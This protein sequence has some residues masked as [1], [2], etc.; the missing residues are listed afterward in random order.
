MRSVLKYCFTIIIVLHAFLFS[1]GQVMVNFS[2]G[3]Y[4]QTIEGLAFAQVVNSLTVDIRG[5]ITIRVRERNQRELVTIKVPSMNFRPGVNMIDRVAFANSKI[6]FGQSDRAYMLSNTGRF[7]EGELEYCYEVNLSESK[8]PNLPDVFEN[9]FTS[10]NQPLTPLLLINPIDEDEM[11]NTRPN[12]S[13]QPPMPLARDARFRIIV[14]EL[15]DKQGPE[16]AISLNIP[17]I[18]QANMATGNLLY[19]AQAPDLKVG[20]KYVWQVTVYSGATIITKSEIWIFTVKCSEEKK[21]VD[22][23]S[24]RELKEVTDG[25]FYVAS[26][27]LRFSFVNPYAPGNLDY[28]I[29]EIAHPDKAIKLYPL[30]MSAG[31]NKYDIDL[32]ELD[33]LKT[34]Q[35]YV[36]KV[37][38]PN[39]RSL[40]L[41]FIYKNE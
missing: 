14:A 37:R 6:I 3:I 32:E 15:K 20:N 30:K 29:T 2:P 16:E 26:K 4:G 34:D 13:W 35:Q 11:C 31:L 41:R 1:K 22:N 33:Q 24:Y 19:P 5:Y 17:V 21:P 40:T 28:S 12:F 36:L 10:L 7:P 39:G 9:C 27:W 18:N 25:S 8:N 38:L 23:D